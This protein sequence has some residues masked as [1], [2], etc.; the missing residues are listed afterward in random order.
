MLLKNGCQLRSLGAWTL[1]VLKSVR[2]AFSL[3]TVLLDSFFEQHA[4][5]SGYLTYDC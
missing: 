4:I 1:H 5:A 2:V 3:A